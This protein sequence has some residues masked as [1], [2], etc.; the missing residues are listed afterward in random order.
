MTA[1]KLVS[2]LPKFKWFRA[3]SLWL[4]KNPSRWTKPFRW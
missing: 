1:K 2:K 4:E 3:V